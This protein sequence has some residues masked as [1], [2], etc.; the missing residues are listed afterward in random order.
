MDY[1]MAKMDLKMD[2]VCFGSERKTPLTDISKSRG[3][4]TSSNV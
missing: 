3:A 4:G 2:M 1:N